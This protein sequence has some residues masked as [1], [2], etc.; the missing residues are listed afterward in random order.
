LNQ[1]LLY[2]GYGLV[3]AAVLSLSAVALTLQY[4]VSRVA[5][6]AHGEL[7]TIGAYGAYEVLQLTNSVPLAA[8]GATVAGGLAGV[9]M[10]LGL[11]ERF[12]GRPAIVIV[13]ATLGVSL[14]LQN[15][16]II[17]FGAANKVYAIDQGSPHHLGPFVLTD[18]EILV[19]VSAAAVATALYLLLQRSKFGKALRAVSDNRD[20]AT[21]SGIPARRVITA[22]WGIAGMIAGFAGFVLAETIGTFT[23]SLGFGYLLITLTAAVAGGLGRPYGTLVGAVLVG[24]V[25]ELAGAYTNSSYQ[26]AFALGVLVILLLFRPNGVL[27]SGRQVA[28]S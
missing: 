19:T 21:A 11:I 20:L 18:A 26:L 4:A 15:L 13:I 27:V 2:V 23:P 5:N 10:N 7:L 22:T 24:L 12:A 1:F 9:A 3:T 28:G 14:V 6:L 17:I 16:L 8:L 25:L